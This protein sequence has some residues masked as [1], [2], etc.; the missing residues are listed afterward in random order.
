[1]TRPW[2]AGLLAVFVIYCGVTVVLTYP[3]ALHLGSVLPN[4]PGDPALN[5]WI[6]W[7]NASTLPYSSAWWNA[8]AFHPVPGVLAFSE[9]LLGLSLISTPLQWAG[10]SPLLAYNIVFL[11]TFPLCALGAYLLA[12]EMTG[13]R[14]AAFLAGLLFGFAPYRMAHLAHVQ[15]LAAFAMPLSLLGL[16]KYLRTRQMRWLA[17]FG[18]GWL[19]QALSNGY[20]MLFFSVLVGF[21][22]LWFLPP[23]RSPRTFG[24]VLAAW[25]ISALPLLPL[26]WHYH[27]I[28]ARLGFTR[29]IGTIRTFSA[30]VLSLLHAA[31]PLEIWGWLQVDRRPEGELFPGLAMVIVLLAS[32]FLARRSEEIHARGWVI[33]RRALAGAM[34]AAGIIAYAIHRMGPWR[35]R[36]S[37][38]RLFIVPD[39]SG[40][41]T[42]VLVL[43]IVLLLTSGPIRRAHA[44]RSALGFYA[45]AAFVMWLFSLGPAPTFAGETLMTHGPYELLMALPGFSSLRVPARFWMMSVLCFA[46]VGAL[47]FDRLTGKRSLFRRAAMAV[48]VLV[49][50]SDAW[51][52]AFPIVPPPDTSMARACGTDSRGAVM[53]LPLGSPLPDIAAM[54]R[55]IAHGR[56]TVNGYSG[57]FPSH[58]DALRYG[59]SIRDEDV[60]AQLSANGVDQIVVDDARDGDEAMR[61]YVAAHAGA[62]LVCADGGRTVYRLSSQAP[63]ASGGVPLSIARIEASINAM[64]IPLMTDGNR[65]TRWHSGPQRRGAMVTIDFGSPRSVSRLELMLGASVRDFPRGL[66]IEGSDD[67]RAWRE[68]WRG[69]SAGRAVIGS[70]EAPRD[71]PLRYDLAGERARYLRLQLTDDEDV[72][73][74]SIAEMRALGH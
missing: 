8:P 45:V 32:V 63:A 57:H 26:L 7:W 62:E 67:Q 3:L 53:E 18:A 4:D 9:H 38:V 51:L 44:A 60:L 30:D 12:F 36:V 42:V 41:I 39:P 35:P 54:Y 28:H 37:G 14:D 50:I 40:P 56:R 16:H 20:Y 55:S 72:Y 5:T 73:Y 17:L 1:M 49:V 61:K 34:I 70:V 2:M 27:T 43:G 15:V 11:L 31:R 47:V 69:R 71:V 52:V 10:A 48:M 24:A 13:R 66:L 29:E 19:I 33:A 64:D 68:I 59:L 23:L 6:F 22:M 21:W 65:N 46:I 74:W 58:Y 25:L